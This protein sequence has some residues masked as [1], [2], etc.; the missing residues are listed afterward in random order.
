MSKLKIYSKYL[1]V[2]LLLL[3]DTKTKVAAQMTNNSSIIETNQTDSKSMRQ[4]LLTDL[5]LAILSGDTMAYVDE[6]EQK[7]IYAY[8]STN[9]NISDE[10]DRNM[11]LYSFIMAE[12]YKY[13]RAAL[14]LA[15]YIMEDFKNRYEEMDSAMT[16]LVLH[17]L[18]VA[19]G[20]GEI[21]HDYQLTAGGRI[22]QLY[23]NNRW[24]KDP[25][26][27]ERYMNEV[28]KPGAKR[29]RIISES[30]KKNPPQTQN[31]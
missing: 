21:E 13:G 10:W 9:G 3:F 6:F 24:L 18:Q 11:L 15:Q 19:V 20:V 7:Y 1:I 25:E 28:L 16:Y 4:Q 26:F 8:M 17:Y 14:N 30:Y 29:L 27:A 22:Y 23:G 2:L 12:K 5:D 31:K